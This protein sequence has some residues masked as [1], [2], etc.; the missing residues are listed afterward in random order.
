SVT[1]SDSLPSAMTPVSVDPA[2]ACHSTPAGFTCTLPTLAAG[3]SFT[4]TLVAQ[5][6]PDFTGTSVSNTAS[7]VSPTP[8]PVSGNNSDT[9]TVAVSR[10]VADV[11]ITKTATPT[12]VVAG[13]RVVYTLTI[14][15]PNGPSNARGLEGTDLLPAGLDAIHAVPSA[16]NCDIRPPVTCIADSLPVGR[17]LTITITAAVSPDAPLGTVTNSAA[18]QTLGSTDPNTANN[19]GSTDITVTGVADVAINK[20][21]TGTPVA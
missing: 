6:G 14:V 10:P 11:A 16:G 8:D 7:A 19:T 17:T 5:V 3:D 18:V 1:L 21:G 12:T 2:N 13:G 20:T 4:A 9:A 15:N